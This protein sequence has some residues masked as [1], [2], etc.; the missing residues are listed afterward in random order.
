MDSEDHE[1]IRATEVV[2]DPMEGLAP[3]GVSEEVVPVGD[4]KYATSAWTRSAKLITRTCNSFDAMFRSEEKS[5]HDG[6]PAH[7]HVISGH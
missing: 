1:E 6:R 7:V 4:G 5:S 3:V 2:L